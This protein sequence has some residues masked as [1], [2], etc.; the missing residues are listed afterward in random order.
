MADFADFTDFQIVFTSENVNNY[1]PRP[2]IDFSDFS[3][4][5]PVF[6]AE[7]VNNYDPRPKID[8]ADFSDIQPV[9][10]GDSLYSVINIPQYGNFYLMK[11]ISTG[12]WYSPNSINLN[13]NN[14]VEIQAL[15]D[16]YSGV[17]GRKTFTA[18]QLKNI[19]SSSGGDIVLVWAESIISGVSVFDMQTN[20]AKVETN[21][22]KTI[23]SFEILT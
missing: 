23:W 21:T 9:F 1:D 15:L 2:K 6:T 14:N 22:G 11:E 12:V 16:N 19:A 18:Q 7:K 10:L 4:I 20:L 13:P 17:A 8:F 5:Q 3:D